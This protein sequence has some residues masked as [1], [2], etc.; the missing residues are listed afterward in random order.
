MD[1]EDVAVTRQTL[2]Q[3]PHPA[4]YPTPVEYDVAYTRW[5]RSGQ[6][7]PTHRVAPMSEQTCPICDAPIQEP[8]LSSTYQGQP[9][10]QFA[11]CANGHRLERGKDTGAGHDWRPQT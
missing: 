4:D 7:A 10:K 3:P 11:Q 1:R 2:V 8:T 6:G 5:K 9:A